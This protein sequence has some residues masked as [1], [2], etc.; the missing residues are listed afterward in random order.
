MKKIALIAFREFI[1]RVRNKTFLLTTILLPI[2]IA[3]FYGAMFFFSSK[4]TETYRIGVIDNSNFFENS[5]VNDSKF[6]FIKLKD[7]FN[8]KSK[9]NA[10]LFNLQA[11]LFAN[12]SLS[13]SNND[14]IKI[15]TYSKIGFISKGDLEDRIQK[16][17][18]T[19][20]YIKHNINTDEMVKYQA[21]VILKFE[22][23]TGNSE[24]E[25]KEGIA[26]GIGYILGFMMYIVLTIYGSQVMRGVMEEKTNRIAEIIV[27]S[28]KPFELLM[29]K[30]IGIGMVSLMQFVVWGI[31]ILLINLIVGIVLGGSLESSMSASGPIQAEMLSKIAQNTEFSNTMNAIKSFHFLPIIIGFVI[32]F[33]GG[34]FLYSSLFAAVG[35]AVNDD[36]QDVQS[37]MMP[38]MLPIFFSFILLTKSINNPNST[39]AVIGS[40]VP[41]TSPVVMMSRLVFGIPEGVPLW[42]LI[43]SIVVL[44]STTIFFIWMAAR[45][46]RVG[47]LLYGKKTNWKEMIQWIF[48][49]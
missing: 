35:S 43:L 9:E 45:I 26:Y 14:S 15:M 24:S 11:V 16:I 4:D 41:F 31:F 28:V 32:Y 13:S 8:F 12:D 33:V 23:K 3:L 49:K 20:R 18:E 2:G 40:I 17:Y 46:Y 44:I 25:L 19:K 27:S 5:L 22:D 39:A 37:L 21:G 38:I 42:Q 1:Q 10:E 36:P 7:T 30:I 29:G 48:I 34:Y 6:E 47:I